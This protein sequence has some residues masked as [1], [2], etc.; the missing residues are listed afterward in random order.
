MTCFYNNFIENFREIAILLR[1]RQNITVMIFLTIYIIDNNKFEDFQKNIYD[2]H[3]IEKK[4]R[5]HRKIYF[6]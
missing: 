6:S 5:L 2:V 4:N 1:S 3:K